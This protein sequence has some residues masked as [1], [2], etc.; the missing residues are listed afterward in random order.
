MSATSA[1]RPGCV[2]CA[3][4]VPEMP[5]VCGPC[6]SPMVY[7]YV[8]FLYWRRDVDREKLLIGL[9]APGLV[10]TS[11]LD[12]DAFDFDPAFRVMYGT[13]LTEVSACDLFL[14]A[15]FL[16][17]HHANVELFNQAGGGVTLFGGQFAPLF[18]TIAAQRVA[19]V[20]DLHGGEINLKRD[21]FVDRTLMLLAGFRYIHFDDRFTVEETGVTRDRN[22][23]AVDATA[24]RKIRTTDNLV[25][26]QVGFEWN[27]NDCNSRWQ[28]GVFGKA[29]L[30]ANLVDGRIEQFVTDSPVGPVASVVNPGRTKAA[31]AVEGGIVGTCQLGPQ[32]YFRGGY[33]F[34]WLG[35]IAVAPDQLP[36]DLFTGTYNGK[37]SVNGDVLFHGPFAGLEWRWGCCR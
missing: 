12:R 35:H 16:G 5:V 31:G 19:Y 28:L 4:I 29:G 1:L 20:S 37:I 13:A 14:E 22:N 17:F 34:L 25:G 6:R 21:Y 23:V 15:G 32:L 18:D 26:L 24:F 10:A 2:G 3:P 7:S 30:Y 11:I 27:T 9:Q 8:D 36:P 33:Q